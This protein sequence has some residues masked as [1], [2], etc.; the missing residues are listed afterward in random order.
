MTIDTSGKFWT[1]SESADLDEYLR[2]LTAQSY[3]AD[4]VV[5]ARCA[6]G[7]DR[8][9]S[10]DA[11]EGC[12]QRTCTACK[13]KHLICDSADSWA[14][15]SAKPVKCPCGGKEFEVAVAFSHRDDGSLKWVTVGER[16]TTCG[17][18]G[19]AVDWKIDYEPTGHLYRSV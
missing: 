5:H 10:V 3:A 15:A 19:A 11:D 6:C 13:Q 4:R 16:C 9:M 18:L 12:A 17:V 1:G 7:S 8:F 14:D 2:A